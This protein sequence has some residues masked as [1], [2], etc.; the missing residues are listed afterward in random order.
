MTGILIAIVIA[1]LVGGLIMKKLHQPLLLGY[2]LAGVFLSI[3][4]RQVESIS[5]S[6]DQIQ[7]LADV[8]V[9]LLLFSVGLEFSSKDLLP[10]RNMALGGALLQVLL[11]FL[12]G[13]AIGRML[14]W[15]LVP[16]AFLGAAI[17]STSTAVVVKTLAARNQMGSL[18]SRTMIGVSIVQ[19]L[20]VIMLLVVLQHV[21]VPTEGHQG[22]MVRYLTP[23]AKGGIFL[24][25]MIWGGRPA[26][27]WLLKKVAHLN[28]Q[29]LFLLSITA[30]SLGIGA[31]SQSL[32]LGFSFGAFIAGIVLSDSDYGK[33]AL[34]EVIPVRDLFSLLFFVSIGMLFDFEFVRANWAMILLLSAVTAFLRS[35]LLSGLSYFFGYRN[36]IPVAMLF[37]MLPTSEIAFL[38]ISVGL[39]L[40]TLGHD[41]Y[42]MILAVVIVTML[43]GPL[44]N[45]LVGPAY[46]WWRKHGISGAVKKITT[47]LPELS[48][49]ILIAGSGAIPRELA[50][51]FVRLNMPCVVVEADYRSFMA[52]REKNIRIVFGAPQEEV[53][54]QAAG[55]E[56]AALLIAASAHYQGNFDIIRSARMLNPTLRII[57]TADD[58]DEL[59]MLHTYKVGEVIRP[60]FEA[61]CRIAARAMGILGMERHKINAA[62]DTMRS[63]KYQESLAAG[64]ENAAGGSA[65]DSC[66]VRITGNSTLCGKELTEQLLD[67]AGIAGILRGSVFDGA[68]TADYRPQPG[69]ML[70]VY[71]ETESVDKLRKLACRASTI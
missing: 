10:I 70:L 47:P 22:W 38:V 33:K 29:E 12:G 57:A 65:P 11:T 41:H 62:L 63:A 56:N 30:I 9:A 59:G 54:L 39:S 2:I 43:G 13:M 17:S 69:D 61:G 16:S 60:N 25:M 46:N 68:M 66:W 4:N 14:D 40:K 53:I 64:Q 49:H 23:L 18:C 28:S 42:S 37:G 67:G 52:M 51:L 36:V 24:V 44:A 19:D 20:A 71:G 35:G 5:I 34:Y 31:L 48:G 27:P 50:E 26:M 7:W 21:C 6:V 15:G 3:L 55:V 45:T 58:D 32:G 8:G 1:G